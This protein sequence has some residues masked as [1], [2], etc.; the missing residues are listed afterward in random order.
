MSR[1]GAAWR[2]AVAA[3][4]GVALSVAGGAL[5]SLL[6]HT[7]EAVQLCV[8]PP[9]LAAGG[10]GVAWL[11]GRQWHI[12]FAVLGLYALGW[13]VAFL[14]HAGPP[15]PRPVLPAV[16]VG[17]GTAGVLAALTGLVLAARAG[18]RRT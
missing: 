9:A 14:A 13:A 18:R 12:A 8:A 2:C 5:G 6:W 16:H 3:L 15:Y 7:P 1:W 17:L 4:A 10:L 11:R